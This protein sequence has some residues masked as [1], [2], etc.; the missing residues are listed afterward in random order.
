MLE[1]L[2]QKYISRLLEFVSLQRS[3]IFCSCHDLF[4]SDIIGS[5]R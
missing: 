5:Y 3:G 2:S 1:F 4:V